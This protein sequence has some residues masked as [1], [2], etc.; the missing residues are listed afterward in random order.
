MSDPKNC[1][2]HHAGPDEVESDKRINV[3]LR[4]TFKCLIPPA[5]INDWLGVGAL[6]LR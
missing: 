6:P 2:Q 3:G 1:P 5:V 4:D